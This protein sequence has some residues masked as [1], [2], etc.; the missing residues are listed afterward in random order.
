MQFEKYQ[1]LFAHYLASSMEFVN[2]E[3]HGD[4]LERV[5]SLQS[6]IAPAVKVFFL[7]LFFFFPFP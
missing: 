5:Y 6:T 7:F 3:Q 4:F 1:K 2:A